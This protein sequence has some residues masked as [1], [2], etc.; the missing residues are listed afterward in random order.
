[1]RPKLDATVPA[2]LPEWIADSL[3]LLRKKRGITDDEL[4]TRRASTRRLCALLDEHARPLGAEA[5]GARWI[6]YLDQRSSAAS[7]L[8]RAAEVDCDHRLARFTALFTIATHRSLPGL[9]WRAAARFEGFSLRP[10]NGDC[11]VKPWEIAKVACRGQETGSLAFFLL[12]QECDAA[13]DRYMAPKRWTLDALEPF[14]RP[15]WP[16]PLQA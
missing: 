10:S 13:I 11:V 4:E 2:A 5:G 6:D 14:L 9:V 16:A 15:G 3:P 1:L 12:G 7:I 8:D